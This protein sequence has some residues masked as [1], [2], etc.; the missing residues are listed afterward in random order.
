MADDIV[1]HSARRRCSAGGRPPAAAAAF[2]G[3]PDLVV[4]ATGRQGIIELG[5]IVFEAGLGER[6]QVS[7]GFARMMRS[8][9]RLAVA[10]RRRNSGKTESHS[11]EKM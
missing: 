11:P 3:Q 1:H 10:M 5:K 4:L 7:A 6:I 9:A 2:V 8:A